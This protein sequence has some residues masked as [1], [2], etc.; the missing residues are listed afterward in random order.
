MNFSLTNEVKEKSHGR[1]RIS[2]LG[3]Y[4]METYAM[5]FGI[6]SPNKMAGTDS[7]H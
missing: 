6:K 1:I 4:H 5:I 7:H 3:S 2:H